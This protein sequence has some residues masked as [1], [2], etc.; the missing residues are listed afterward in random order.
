MVIAF[1]VVSLY[2]IAALSVILVLVNNSQSNF[3]FQKKRK[4]CPFLPLGCS[5]CSELKINDYN[6]DNNNHIECD[7][8]VR[9]GDNELSTNTK[10][11]ACYRCTLRVCDCEYSIAF[12]VVNY[13]ILVYEKF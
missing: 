3:I 6:D 2:Q 7:N 1:Y 13:G 5:Q 11:V 12:H 10:Y 4:L 8:I 9:T